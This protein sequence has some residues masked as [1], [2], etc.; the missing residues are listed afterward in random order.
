MK[1]I[2]ISISFIIAISYSL[3]SQSVINNN[4]PYT[5]GYFEELY[6][7]EY[8]DS[9]IWIDTSENNLWEIGVPKKEIL[10]QAYSDSLAIITK[11][12]DYYQVSNTSYFEFNL[13]LPDDESGL[14]TIGEGRFNF[15]HK[16]NTEI[17]KAG[18]YI[19]ISYDDGE[20]WNNALFDLTNM[21][22]PNFQNF[23]NNTDT[24]DDGTP[25]FQG[26]SED[27]QESQ[28]WWFWNAMVKRADQPEWW[29]WN[30]DTLRVRFAFK[31]L[32]NAQ[33]NYEGWM[34]DDLHITIQRIYGDV[35]ELARN[36][37]VIYPNPANSIV[38]LDELP[39]HS[40]NSLQILNSF[41]QLVYERKNITSKNLELNIENLIPGIYYIKYNSK[42]FTT[43]NY[44]IK[45]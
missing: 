27:W 20:T 11:I 39:F 22:E 30:N 44:F 8:I 18:G 10:N 15:K 26:I 33:N 29:G 13:T 1:K 25:C 21:G 3:L 35:D 12:S 36:N 40:K 6:T 24:L 4:T 2:S 37:I 42:G 5:S 34:I 43:S 16:Y 14:Q 32:N 19:E 45:L 41:G 7:F 9:H 17:G 23:Y 28:I 31:C 38:Y